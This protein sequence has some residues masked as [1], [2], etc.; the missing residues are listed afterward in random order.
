LADGSVTESRHS[1]GLDD[2]WSSLGLQDVVT[3]HGGRASWSFVAWSD[4]PG[5][6]LVQPLEGT[7]VEGSSSVTTGSSVA[8][9]GSVLDSIS[10]SG[11]DG[12]G[13]SHGS[14]D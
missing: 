1:G 13:S 9:F 3:S 4:S 6:D 8:S 2:T 11:D 10:A 7:L 14:G 12:H 5:A